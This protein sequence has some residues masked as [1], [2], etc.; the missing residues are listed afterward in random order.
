V[1]D[2]AITF[3][4]VNVGG[5]LRLAQC[6]RCGSLLAPAARGATRLPAA[7]QHHVDQHYQHDRLITEIAQLHAAVTK[8]ETGGRS[9][10]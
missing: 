6:D 9:G 5:F 4:T 1:S 3:S 7:Q 2:P 8:D 10:P